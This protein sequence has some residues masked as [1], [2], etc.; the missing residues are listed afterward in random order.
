M[1]GIAGERRLTE[2]ELDWLPGY[3][4]SRPV[5]IGNGAHDQLQLDVYGE[6]LDAMHMCRRMGMEAHESWSV[7]TALLEF[8]ESNWHLP[9][10]GIWEIRGPRRQFT[11]SKVMA[12]VAFD[13]AVKAVENFSH[14]GPLE[15]WRTLRD[16]IHSE[17]CER[18]YNTTLKTFTQYYGGE[19]L[20]ASV[21]L[22]PLV[23]FLPATDA[24]MLGTIRAIEQRLMQHGFVMR[25][26]TSHQ[27]DGLKGHEGAFLACSFWMVD[28]LVM[29][30][31]GADAKALFER[32]LSIRN[33]VG[34]LAEEYD[35]GL[36][37]LV[38]NFP[39]AFSHLALVN[40]AQLLTQDIPEDHRD[41]PHPPSSV[42]FSRRL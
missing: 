15:R 18:G 25:Y 13:R 23:G 38:G 24:R 17:V 14:D 40:S 5:R 27:V 4:G 28:N 30:G 8:L 2:M 10:E 12:W 32:L 20:D 33:D 36:G 34:L 42:L 21:L 35:T 39:Q 11:H 22:I 7:E 41:S 31:R 37:R 1:Y 3:E 26:D 6:L 29:S 16:Q 19:P 9:D